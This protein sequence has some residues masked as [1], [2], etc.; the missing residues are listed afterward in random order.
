MKKDH[1]YKDFWERMGS[2]A[3]TALSM[4]DGSPN[5]ETCQLTGQ[6]MAKRISNALLLNQEDFVL[7][8][9]CGV[10]RIGRE[11]APLCQRWF[12]VDISNNLIKIAEQRMGHLN[13]VEFTALEK[14][15]LHSYPDHTFDKVYSHAV[16][17]HMDKEDLFLYLKEIARVLKSGGLLYFDTWN[18]KN[19]VGWE[20]WMMEVEAWAQSDQKERKHVSRNQFSTP[21]ELCLYVEKSGLD[22]LFS[23]SDSFWIQEIAVKPGAEDFNRRKEEIRYAILQRREKI[24]I[25]ST[26][27]ELFGQHL[28]LLKGQVSPLEFSQFILN[29][30]ENEEVNLYRQWLAALWKKNEKEWG[31]HPEKL[32]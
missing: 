10:G 25:N 29:K 20:R 26:L 15:S 19:T 6:Y 30:K 13:N 22:E 16:F 31:P 27:I 28:K 17:I 9:G 1:S 2:N 21:D 3:N 18:L 11:I 8:L 14:T 4:M 12:G 24:A 7:E 5:E 23:F 32:K